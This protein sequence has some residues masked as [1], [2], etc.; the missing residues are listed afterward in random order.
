MINFCN[1]TSLRNWLTQFLNETSRF[2]LHCNFFHFSNSTLVPFV[3]SI[4]TGWSCIKIAPETFRA[5]WVAYAIIIIVASYA[6]R[7]YT[8]IS[9]RTSAVF[10]SSSSCDCSIF[11][12]IPRFWW[13]DIRSK[14][15]K[16]QS[17]Q[18]ALPIIQID[19]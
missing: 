1:I 18:M 19:L 14:A 15:L 9:T 13:R 4:R 16:Y 10:V 17:S 3:T 6:A 11:H 2:I 8:F 5:I 12:A 7:F